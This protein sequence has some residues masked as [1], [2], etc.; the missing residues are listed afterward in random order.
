MNSHFYVLLN[1]LG[2][3]N[4]YQ[5][6][7]ICSPVHYNFNKLHFKPIKVFKMTQF[8]SLSETLWFDMHMLA[9]SWLCLIKKNNLTTCIKLSS[10]SLVIKKNTDVYFTANV[11]VVLP[12]G[13]T[14]RNAPL[15]SHWLAAHIVLSTHRPMRSQT[16]PLGLRPHRQ[17]HRI[18][19]ALGIMPKASFDS[20]ERTHDDPV[21]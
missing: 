20:W 21:D 13:S 16:A 14:E 6:I 7:H 3:L 12:V 5:T 1:L 9:Y 11:F 15:S 17:Y 19:L 18:S 2:W 8:F 10:F 4:K